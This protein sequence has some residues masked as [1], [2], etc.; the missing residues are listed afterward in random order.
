MDCYLKEVEGKRL[1]DR[2]VDSVMQTRRLACSLWI[3]DPIIVGAGASGLATAACLRRQGVPSLILE[4]APCTAALWRTKAYDRLRLHL[5]KHFCELPLLSFPDHF[6][7]YPTKD[8]FLAYLDDYANQFGLRPVFNRTVTG[9]KFDRSLQ[10]WTV[11][12]LSSKGDDE[13]EYITKWLI[14]ASGENAEEFVPKFDGMSEFGGKIIHTSSYKSGEMFKGK[15]VLIVGCGNSGM[16]VCLDLYN[17]GAQASI[18]VRDSVHVLPQEMLGRS[19]FGLSMWL[20]KWLSI[21]LVDQFLLL[22]SLFT[23]GDT[24]KYGF[25]RPKLGPLQ[26]K[27]MT[28]KTPV[29][30]VGTLSKIRS[31]DIKVYRGIKKFTHGAVEFVDGKVESFDAIIFA[32]GYKSNVPSWL[33]D[34]DMFCE[35]G[36]PRKPFPEGWKGKSGLYAVGFTRR[37]LLGASIDARRVAEDIGKQWKAEN[38]HVEVRSTY[39]Q[40]EG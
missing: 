22:M 4:R 17:Y 6:P 2:P 32:T 12:T 24:A 14:V 38:K 30:D 20:L 34:T 29:L 40:R 23:L 33:K 39:G 3:P 25:V 8:Q 7:T 28:G 31:G 26:L 13:V 27:N 5:P 21:K 16:E 36:F 35:D 11:K 9:A 1:H 10:A 18:V 37:G 15:N 19:T